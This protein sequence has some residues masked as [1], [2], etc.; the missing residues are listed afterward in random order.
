MYCSHTNLC[1]TEDLEVVRVE[2]YILTIRENAAQYSVSSGVDGVDSVL[3]DLLLSLFI[4][5]VTF[6]PCELIL[7]ECV[8]IYRCFH[9]KC[10]YN[11]HT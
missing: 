9:C 6:I 11:T 8:L 7:G 4:I 2:F 5:T 3:Y 10:G 1:S